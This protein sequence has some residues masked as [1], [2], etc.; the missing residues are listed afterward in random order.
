MTEGK[1]S[2]FDTHPC[3]R[4][5]I[6]SAQAERAAG[7]FQLEVPAA[8]LLRNFEAVSQRCSLA[9]YADQIEEQ[10]P[11]ESLVQSETYLRGQ[12]ERDAE[13]DALSA[14]IDR[15]LQS[16]RDLKLGAEL[17]TV[18]GDIAAESERLR[19]AR[20][21]IAE[22]KAS[23]RDR[24]DAS[25]VTHQRWV[26]GLQAEALLGAGMKVDAASFGL[27]HANAEAAR[28]LTQQALHERRHGD[29]ELT[30]FDAAVSSYLSAGLKLAL[31]RG[32]PE[33]ME[34]ERFLPV[35]RA[36]H[37]QA[38]II[39]DLE[40][41]FFRQAG[42]LNNLEG[43]DTVQGLRAAVFERSAEQVVLLRKLK[44]ALK[45]VPYP[46]E[47]R[48]RDL[49]LA[50]AIVVSV[51]ADSEEVGTVMNACAS[52]MQRVD[53]ARARVLARLLIIASAAEAA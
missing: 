36:L 8:A 10:V 50:D 16:D 17:L 41:E 29:G 15:P 49:T 38:E 13:L 35:Y 2:A 34:L 40:R 53:R 30:S 19:A 25:D 44:S 3:D 7:I 4:E 24:Y 20:A 21:Q 5:R 46:F 32:L 31:A 45:G 33:A 11:A 12:R 26:N 42:L 47:H 43:N 51:P 37:D 18:S 52:A 14:F 28:T 6:A 22:L 39:E 9:L 27:A 1:T 48:E 23:V